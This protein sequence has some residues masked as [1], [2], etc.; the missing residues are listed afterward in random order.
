MLSYIFPG[1]SARTVVWVGMRLLSN[2]SVFRV[3]LKKPD[4]AIFNTAGQAAHALLSELYMETVLQRR[5]LQGDNSGM[6][7]PYHTAAQHHAGV[8]VPPFLLATAPACSRMV[9]VRHELSLIHI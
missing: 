7:R 6:L 3:P 2:V 5:A 4:M 8:P 9:C 1:F